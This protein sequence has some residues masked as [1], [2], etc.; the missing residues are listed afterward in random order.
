M[1]NYLFETRDFLEMG[2]ADCS[3]SEERLAGQVYQDSE[4][5]ADCNFIKKFNQNFNPQ[6]TRERQEGIGS[7]N[8]VSTK[9]YSNRFNESEI[10]KNLNI[11]KLRISRMVEGA[12]LAESKFNDSTISKINYES[13][14]P[15]PFNMSKTGPFGRTDSKNYLRKDSQFEDAINRKTQKDLQDFKMLTNLSKINSSH[16]QAMFMSNSSKPSHRGGNK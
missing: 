2:E 6:E 11:S 5:T 3:E 1:S 4:V 9:K 8:D 16:S 14:L 10:I 15:K 13:V 12:P 7:S